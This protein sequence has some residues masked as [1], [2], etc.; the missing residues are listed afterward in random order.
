MPPHTRSNVA[1]CSPAGSVSAIAQ[2]LSGGV[3]LI[4]EQTG[5]GHA[6]VAELAPPDP[7]RLVRLA[8]GAEPVLCTGVDPLAAFDA[9]TPVTL[10][11]AITGGTA[12]LV[13]G[14]REVL[15]CSVTATER[16]AWGIASLG[17]RAQLAVDSVTVAR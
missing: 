6:L 13:L 8:G 11:F 1:V 4:A 3:A 5:P 16:G 14:D 2:V 15:S 10:R 7:P 12:R 17:A 9:L